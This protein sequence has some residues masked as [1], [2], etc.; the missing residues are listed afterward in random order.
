[1]TTND[2]LARKIEGVIRDHLGALQEMVLRTVAQ[3]FSSAARDQ[4][5]RA[6]GKAAA[7]AGAPARPKV[8]KAAPAARRAPDE[9]AALAERLDAAVRA[10]PGETMTTLAA[11][12]GASPRALQVVVGRL[13]RAGRVRSVGQ[14]QCTRYFPRT[15]GT[16]AS[17]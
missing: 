11:T 14:R 17:A 1:M 2:E 9:I 10:A 15:G 13:K 8:A 12:V 3:S 4:A 5:A 6:G 7:R 16:E